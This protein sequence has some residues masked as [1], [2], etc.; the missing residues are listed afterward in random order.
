[1]ERQTQR[2]NYEQVVATVQM[3]PKLGRVEKKMGLQ[4]SQIPQHSQNPLKIPCY[5]KGERWLSWKPSFREW[6]CLVWTS[7]GKSCT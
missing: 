4:N 6:P 2:P 3:G 5:W 7:K 1:M